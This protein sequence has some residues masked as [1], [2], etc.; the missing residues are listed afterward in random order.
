MR[1]AQLMHQTEPG[2]L[3]KCLAPSECSNSESASRY[4]WS[5]IRN[6]F[7]NVLD[8][9]EIEVCW[10]CMRAFMH[11][12]RCTFLPHIGHNAW[13]PHLEFLFP[14][15]RFCVSYRWTNCYL[16]STSKHAYI[17]LCVCACTYCC[18]CVYIC[19]TNIHPYIHSFIHIDVQVVG[20]SGMPPGFAELRT[21]CCVSILSEADLQQKLKRK[22]IHV[23]VFVYSTQSREAAYEKSELLL[24]YCCC[25]Y[26]S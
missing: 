20:L 25:Y 8:T 2:C 1:L 10:I 16:A 4:V 11:T 12:C 19:N 17:L 3:L 21:Y 13:W 18:V 15:T 9:M 23:F 22:H 6:P 26:I 5:N 7:Q 14:W 24:H